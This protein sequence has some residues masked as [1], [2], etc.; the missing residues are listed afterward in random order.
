MWVNLHRGFSKIFVELPCK[1]NDGAETYILPT[2]CH[3]AFVQ[4]SNALSYDLL[5]GEI[6]SHCQWLKNLG[7]N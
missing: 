3:P 5:M 1:I 6:L 4:T 7:G 2:D